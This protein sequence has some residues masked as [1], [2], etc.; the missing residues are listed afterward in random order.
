MAIFYLPKRFFQASP[1]LGNTSWMLFAEGAARGSRL[2]TIIALASYLSASDYG[3]AM[4]ALVCYELLRVVTRL[5]AGAAIIQCTDEQLSSTAG[6]AH[7]LNWS[8]G[9]TIAVLQYFCAPVLADFYQKPLLEPLL[10]IM[11][12]SYVIYPIVMV[13]AC[14]VQRSNNMKYFALC[15]ALAVM[16]DNLSTALLVYSGFGVYAVAWAKIIAA[17]VWL[18]M[19]L[20][21]KVPTIKPSYCGKTMVR[22]LVFSIKVLVSD[23]LKTGRSQID[24]LLAG[25]LLSPE[26]FGLYSFAKSA[27]VGLGQSL[28]NAYL[29]C[30]YPRMASLQRNQKLASEF[31][32]MFLIAL[33]ISSIFIAQ[34]LMAPI[35]IPLLF[36]NDWPNPSILVAVLCLSAIPCLLVDICALK[37]RVQYQANKEI[38][39][40]ATS[41]LSL[42]LIL[43][44]FS[45]TTPLSFAACTV[46]VS[47]SWLLL[48]PIILNLNHKTKLQQ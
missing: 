5:G 17:L 39:L 24:V 1:L 32:Q 45:P 2:I 28:S 23:F 35:Y 26:L 47:F 6:N 15:S 12:F 46:A 8:I 20:A 3:I 38:A 4:L 42:V 31:R 48:L 11:A 7:L 37:L 13:R 43:V 40:Q 19:F 34:S 22:L 14:L 18:G 29:C 36:H 44:I 10:Q 41:M 27:G 25:K 21:A 33:G 16:T 30:I 9:L